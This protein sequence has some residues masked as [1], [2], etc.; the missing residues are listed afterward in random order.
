[1]GNE[2]EQLFHLPLSPISQGKSLL[3]PPKGDF[4]LVTF[5][6]DRVEVAACSR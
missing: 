6:G 3:W 4:T 5:V 2:W 1:M